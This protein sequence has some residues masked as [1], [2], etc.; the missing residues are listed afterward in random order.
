MG[1]MKAGVSETNLSPRK[2]SAPM[3]QTSSG[4]LLSPDEF[5]TPL[6]SFR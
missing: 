6:T 1:V 4:S 2:I 5:Y 3:P